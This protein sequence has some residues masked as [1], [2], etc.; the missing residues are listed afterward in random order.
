MALHRRCLANT[1]VERSKTASRRAA[2]SLGTSS[3]LRNS[4]KAESAG[5][6]EASTKGGGPLEG[7]RIVVVPRSSYLTAIL[8]GYL[9]GYSRVDSSIKAL[10][11]KHKEQNQ[12]FEDAP[13]YLQVEHE[14]RWSAQTEQ[15]LRNLT[16]ALYEMLPR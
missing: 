12:G 13:G 7:A 5:S 14:R 6:G 8:G 1:A 11:W 15:D 2:Y 3:S 4:R 9:L 16:S 10:L